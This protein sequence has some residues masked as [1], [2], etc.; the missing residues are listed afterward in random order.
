ML[1]NFL[2]AAAPAAPAAPAATDPSCDA[3]HLGAGGTQNR[4][5]ALMA[6]AAVRDV[7]QT[8]SILGDPTRVRIL[9]ALSG[10][11]L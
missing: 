9:D 1:T 11:E 8:F 5:R 4:R 10:G 6:D 7:A 3:A 2:P